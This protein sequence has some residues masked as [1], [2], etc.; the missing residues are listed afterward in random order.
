MSHFAGEV[1]MV[2]DRML[3]SLDILENAPSY[4]TRRSEK[5]FLDGK[6]MDC[7]MYLLADF[8]DELL[9]NE[10]L[11]EYTASHGKPY[12]PWQ[13]FLE[14]HAKYGPFIIRMLFRRLQESKRRY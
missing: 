11:K 12:V 1:Y 9:S 2:D 3:A 13:V 14:F 5:V 7:H 4:Y 8:K 10:F 6:H